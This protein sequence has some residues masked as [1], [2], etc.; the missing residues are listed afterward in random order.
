MFD[1]LRCGKPGLLLRIG[2]IEQAALSAPAWNDVFPFGEW[3]APF[4]VGFAQKEFESEF[5]NN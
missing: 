3:H 4:T 5:A 2:V 1:W